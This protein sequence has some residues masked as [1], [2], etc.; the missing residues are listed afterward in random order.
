MNRELR[1]T[2]EQQNIQFVRVLWCDN[3]NVI[4]GKAFHTGFL[5]E[6]QQQGIS[7]AIAQQA[8]P[9]M[10]DAVA[11]DSGLGPVGEA[12]LVPDWSTF[13]ALPYTP[14]H[15]SVMGDMVRGGEPW[16]LCPRNFL[17]RMI[18]EADAEGLQVLAAFENEFYLLRSLVPDLAAQNLGA[19]VPADATVFASTLA[20]DLNYSVIGDIAEALLAQGIPVERYYPESGG[21]QHE[22]AI[23]YT[24]A[25]QSADW[26]IAFRETVR[27]VALRHQLRASFLPKIF[28]DQAGSGC[29]LH[30][31]LWRQGQNLMPGENG[32]LSPIARTF[33]GGI[34][35]HLPALMAL[36][37]PSVNSYR[38]L[39]PHFWSGAFRCWGMDNRE[40]A[41]RVPSNPT[42][43]SPTHI[44]LKT[45]DA[46]ANPYLALG[47]TIAAGLDGIRR[48]LDPGE[49]LAIDPGHL[50][51]A[52][53]QKRG[54]ERLP[55]TLGEAI[56]HFSCNKTLL[57]ALGADFFRAFLAVRRMEWKALQGKTLEEEVKLL[58]E[59]Y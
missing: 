43:P 2:L 33:I 17:K 39:Q 57:N 37:T 55:A 27:G 38:R 18:A 51:E 12:W 54:I 23:R 10:Y 9:V 8:I 35:H 13:N 34:L 6:H 59:R 3:A 22:I 49:P 45:V 53:R 29:H 41:V 7:I 58:M 56:E 52:E 14:G 15:A 40:A 11:P 16:A 50:P 48:G 30:L 42:A 46:S 25:L 36:T 19:I 44:E 21:G 24:Q 31:S 47:A 1:Q 5:A 4:R 32:E 28:A 20:M 26:Q